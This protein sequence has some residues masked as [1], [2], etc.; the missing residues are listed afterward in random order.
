MQQKQVLD[1]CCGGK[2][3]YFDKSIKDVLFCDNRK[4]QHV[5]CDGRRFDVSPDII[6]DFEKL[7]FKDNSYNLV[8]FDP[9]HLYEAGKESWLAKKYGVLDK[10]NWQ[11]ILTKG[12]NECWRVLKDGGTLI[13]KWNEEQIK[14]KDVLS[15]FPVKPLFGHTGHNTKTHWFCFY[16]RELKQTDLSELVKGF[17]GQDES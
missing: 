6:T 15:L 8:V 14:K 7:P 17:R 3:F 9:P 4:E 1:V 13:F 10:R 16:K 12:F 2:M 5:L 11:D